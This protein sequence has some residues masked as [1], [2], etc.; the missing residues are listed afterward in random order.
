MIS[1]I[2]DLN[3]YGFYSIETHDAWPRILSG[4]GATDDALFVETK[5]FSGSYSATGE[6]P[7]I[8]ELT[9]CEATWP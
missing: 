5:R 3:V 1:L 2:Q 9:D 6:L 8:I 4:V 7:S